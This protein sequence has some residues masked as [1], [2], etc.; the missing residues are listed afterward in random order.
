MEPNTEEIPT[1]IPQTDALI[2]QAEVLA[3]RISDNPDLKVI[4]DITHRVQRATV[5]NTIYCTLL[6][7]II[8]VLSVVAYNTWQNGNVVE[9]LQE[10]CQQDNKDKADD[11]A[12]WKFIISLFPPSPDGNKITTA[13]L[14]SREQIDK[15]VEC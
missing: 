7:I 9:G 13:I 11:L 5:F 15:P 8:T 3:Q 2:E 4:L 10:S 1:T 14:A 6:F 12:S